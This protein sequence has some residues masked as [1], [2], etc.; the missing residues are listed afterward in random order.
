MPTAGVAGTVKPLSKGDELFA[1]GGTA[2]Y[3]YKVVSGTIRTSK[4]LADGR[5]QIDAFHIQGDIF[6]IETGSE[7][8]FSAEAIDSATVVA[9]RRNQL[10]QLTNADLNFAQQVMGSMVRNLQRAQDHMLLLGRKSAVEKMATFLLDL[11]ERLHDD[12]EIELPM[13]RSDIADHLG[14][15]IE[16][17]SRTLACM[18][19]QGVIKIGAGKRSILLVDKQGL[20]AMNG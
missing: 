18:I 9:Y 20:Q 4:L 2:D 7:H 14:L 16:T 1:D 15:T 8:R 12:D 10:Q 6:G 17:V 3:F 13:S 11:A 5:R 19:K